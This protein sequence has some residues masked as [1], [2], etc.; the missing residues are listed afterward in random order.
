MTLRASTDTKKRVTVCAEC[1]TASCWNYEF[2]CEKYREAGTV[3]KT[4][5][6]LMA[7]GREH[8]DNWRQS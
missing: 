1:L 7:L 6:E 3:E 4:V 2:V 5:A 8:S